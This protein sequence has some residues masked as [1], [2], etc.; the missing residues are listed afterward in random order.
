VDNHA[1]AGSTAQQWS[2][3]PNKLTEWVKGKRS[4]DIW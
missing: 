4:R 1:V 2:L 3:V